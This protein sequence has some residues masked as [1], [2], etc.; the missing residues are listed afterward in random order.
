MKELDP[1]PQESYYTPD[2]ILLL[3]S[4]FGAYLASGL[5]GRFIDT[6]DDFAGT[7]NRT[8]AQARAARSEAPIRLVMERGWFSDSEGNRF[9]TGYFLEKF[10][11]NTG[12]TLIDTDDEEVM[13]WVTFLNDEGNVLYEDKPNYGYADSFTLEDVEL[14]Y[15]HGKELVAAGLAEPEE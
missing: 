12:D 3:K 1:G 10:N 13:C 14:L 8:T 2:E 11:P 7:C 15:Q 6:M 9:G 5:H 4:H